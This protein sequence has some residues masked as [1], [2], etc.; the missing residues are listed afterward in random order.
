MSDTPH[1]IF[2]LLELFDGSSVHDRRHHSTLLLEIFLVED[3]PFPTLGQ[4][5]QV[6]ADRLGLRIFLN[7]EFASRESGLLRVLKGV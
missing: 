4:L 1:T 6:V 3:T 5:V 2:L 7:Q